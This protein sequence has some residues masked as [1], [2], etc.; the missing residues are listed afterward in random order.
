ML[1]PGPGPLR[2]AALGFLYW[3]ALVTVLEPGNILRGGTLR[4]E[5]EPIRLVA[6][7]LLGASI[8]PLVSA[9]TRRLP[10]EG[11]AWWRRAAIHLASD[12]GLA[13]GLIVAA[14]LLAALIGFDRRPLGAALL[15]QLA[16]DGLLLF[17]ALVGLTGLAHAELFRRRV[18]R[19]LPVQPAPA[20][21][22]LAYLTMVP[23][24]ARGRTLMLDL[25]EVGWIESQGNYLALHAGA[26]THLIRETSSRF[27]AAL[28]PQRFV[29]IHR[30]TIVALHRIREI[31]SLPS[32]DA[33]VTLTDGT[34]LRMSRGYRE[35]VKRKFEERA[36]L[37]L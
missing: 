11:K 16:V 28:D 34:S 3:L 5:W 15:N 8:T 10:I 13:V 36:N 32:G 30:Q 20:A 9:L 19:A 26:A 35:A 24:T 7:G 4:W 37:E 21:P 29:R 18:A 12:A 33:T 6:A 22:A 1:I 2:E 25:A 17:F 23:V 31:A 27:E 14:G